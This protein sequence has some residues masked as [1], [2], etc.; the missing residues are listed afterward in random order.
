MS[1]VV[2]PS[3]SARKPA[4][5]TTS[6]PEISIRPPG[7][8][9][10]GSRSHSQLSRARSTEWTKPDGYVGTAPAAGCSHVVVTWRSHTGM[11]SPASDRVASHV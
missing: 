6:L 4:E 9:V 11:T 3:R 2:R 7:T 10:P 8:T 5:Q 1:R